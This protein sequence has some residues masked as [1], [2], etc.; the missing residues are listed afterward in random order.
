LALVAAAVVTALLGTL[1]V[2]PAFR[3][4]AHYVAIAT[5]GIGEIVNQVILNWAPLTNG[6]MGLGN[7][8]AP[9]LLGRQVISPRDVYWYALGLL[10]L[11]A[12]FQ[13]RL[14]RSALGR[15]WRAIREDDVA[16]QAYGVS[17][18]RYKALAFAAS[19]FIAGLGGAFTAHMYTYINHE[20]FTNS[21]SI[22]ALTMVILGG[23]GNMVGAVVGALALTAMPELF[24]GLADYRYLIYGL[25]LL[26][27]IRFRPQ[28]LLGTV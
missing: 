11:V 4:R 16:A 7:I 27:L 15:T 10:L 28:G 8:P 25:A 13:W 18:N 26:M 17:L 20:T 3:L 19:G 24:R 22:L 1:L 6:V 5:L 2:L 14:V 21:T 9:T 23:M 12:V